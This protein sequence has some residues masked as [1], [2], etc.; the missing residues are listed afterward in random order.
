[1]KVPLHLTP[2]VELLNHN[3]KIFEYVNGATIT[4]SAPEGSTVTIS[5]NIRTNDVV[6]EMF[7][8]QGRLFTYTQTTTAVNGTYNLIVPYSTLGPIPGET[9]FDTRPTGSY[10]ITAGNVTQSVDVAEQD[11]LN[12]G[13]IKV[14]LMG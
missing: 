6:T 7:N 10:S 8:S 13:T 3:I 9:N 2:K 14:N 4:G 11:V 1:M 5:N 12:S